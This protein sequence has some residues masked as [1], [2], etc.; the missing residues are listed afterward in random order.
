MDT[1]ALY[2]AAGRGVG[3]GGGPDICEQKLADVRLGRVRPLAV[4]RPVDS[5][6]RDARLASAAIPAARPCVR[7]TAAP[8]QPFGPRKVMLPSFR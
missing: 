2:E 5:P 4:A 8:G 1:A 7:G 3:P 6:P